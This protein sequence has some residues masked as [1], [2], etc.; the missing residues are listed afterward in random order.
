MN[1]QLYKALVST[2]DASLSFAWLALPP[3]RKQP[4]W[5]CSVCLR[6]VFPSSLQVILLSLITIT[7]RNNNNKNGVSSHH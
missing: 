2:E 7:R 1:I 4:F 5:L 3:H 6:R